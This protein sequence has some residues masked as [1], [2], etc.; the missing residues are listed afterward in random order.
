MLKWIGGGFDP[1][2]FHLDRINKI[3]AAAA[4]GGRRILPR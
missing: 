3:L 4:G 2:E 1:E